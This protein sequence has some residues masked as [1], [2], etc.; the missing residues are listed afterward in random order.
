MAGAMKAA[1]R[2]QRKGAGLEELTLEEEAALVKEANLLFVD[3]TVKDHT[4]RDMVLGSH[5]TPGSACADNDGEGALDTPEP[6]PFI[7]SNHN[8]NSQ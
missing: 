2:L 8:N 5:P 1:E 7:N 6:H 3:H 4:L